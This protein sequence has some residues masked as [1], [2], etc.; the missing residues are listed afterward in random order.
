[1]NQRVVK[2][3]IHL[4]IKKNQMHHK[5]KKYII[6]QQKIMNRNKIMD[7]NNPRT[8]SLPMTTGLQCDYRVVHGPILEPCTKECLNN[9]VN[10]TILINKQGMWHIS[11]QMTIIVQL[12]LESQDETD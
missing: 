4:T 7:G 12:K 1:M 3:I 10:N 2:E 11:V 9:K 5:N 6:S 8:I